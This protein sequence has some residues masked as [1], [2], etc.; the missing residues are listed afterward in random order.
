MQESIFQGTQVLAA[1]RPS[2]TTIALVLRP[3]GHKLVVVSGDHAGFIGQK[4]RSGRILVGE[5]T[6]DNARAVRAH[7]PWLNPVPLGVRASMGLGDRLG[8][9]TPGHAW[10]AEGQGIAPVFAQ[11]S[12][13]E[14]VRTGRTPQQVLDDA[15]WG[16]F[17]SGWRGDWGADADHVKTAEDLLPFV[18]AGFTSYTI[19]PGEYV[20]DEVEHV[21]LADVLARLANIN[22]TGIGTS[23]Q[24]LLARYSGFVTMP[25]GDTLHLDEEAVARGAAKY[26]HALLCV[27]ELYAVLREHMAN[28]AFDLEIS[29]DETAFATRPIEHFI[30]AG[31]LKRLGIPFTALA[32]RFVGVFQR[33]VEYSG[34]LDSLAADF[35]GH[36]AVQAYYGLSYKISLHSG[37]DKF[38]VYPL[39]KTA[40]GERVHIKTSGTSYLLALEVLARLEPALFRELYAA[41]QSAFPVDRMTTPVSARPEDVPALAGLRDGQL[42]GL[43]ALPAVRQMLHITYGAVLTLHGS[44]LK[45]ALVLHHAAYE[46]DLVTHLRK[47]MKPLRPRTTGPLVQ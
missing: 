10:A 20:D 31:E 11:Q 30:F 26:G 9:A 16:A 25:N 29:L 12:V 28:R 37:S 2:D 27:A 17:E 43:L 22:F 6:P 23:A 8:L 14:N 46:L 19:D 34:S 3:N 44:S 36:A 13:R 33:G 42:S 24:D 39:A 40:F 38:S 4:S 18:Q 5:L 32:P 15:M 1:F 45:G 21:P 7:I 41:A 35:A 47:H